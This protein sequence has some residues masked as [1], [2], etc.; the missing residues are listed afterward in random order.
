M[1]V[2]TYIHTYIY[3]LRGLHWCDNDLRTLEELAAVIR[4]RVPMSAEH[5]AAAEG[6]LEK[7]K[8]RS[9]EAH[10]GHVKWTWMETSRRP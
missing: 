9:T 8:K 6:Q 4:Q 7:K 10:I 5:R 3:P 2:Y 1:Y